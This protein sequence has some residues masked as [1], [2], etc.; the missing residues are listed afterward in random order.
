MLP[1]KPTGLQVRGKGRHLDRISARQL[2]DGVHERMGLRWISGMRGE[3]RALDPGA[4]QSR[5]PSLIG[6]LNVIYPNKI[7][8][9]GTEELNFLDGLDSRQRWE[10]IHKVAAYQPVALIV[11]KDQAI[12]ADLREVAEGPR[13]RDGGQ[14]C[15]H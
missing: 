10:V 5:R 13:C 8:I 12:P 7:Q 15:G 2:Y 1:H 6:Y 9:I 3:A 11:S 4:T 14:R